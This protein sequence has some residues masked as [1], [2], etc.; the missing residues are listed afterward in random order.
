VQ[1]LES[2][3]LESSTKAVKSRFEAEIRELA[4]ELKGNQ[5]KIIQVPVDRRIRIEEDD[6][7]RSESSKQSKFKSKS[8]LSSASPVRKITDLKKRVH[9][10]ADSSRSKN[11]SEFSEVEK[12]LSFASTMAE[13]KVEVKPEEPQVQD[14][15]EVKLAELSVLEKSFDLA[16]SQKL[17]A[18]IK[19]NLEALEKKR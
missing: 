16:K 7:K 13:T 2:R 11:K 19:V 14:V 18:R 12:N 4:E 6:D 15:E 8:S 1:V 9:K 17:E 10:M 3:V 5:I